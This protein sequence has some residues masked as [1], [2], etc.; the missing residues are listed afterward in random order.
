M[1]LKASG[2]NSRRSAFTV[3]TIVEEMVTQA[4][5]DDDSRVRE[6]GLAL[7]AMAP[8]EMKT[9]ARLSLAYTLAADRS[10]RVRL[11]LAL[12]LNQTRPPGTHTD[13]EPGGDE[14]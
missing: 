1:G 6:A 5:R 3:K 7:L 10:S 14:C 11:Q 9:P 4:L 12:S 8:Q 13:G 2:A